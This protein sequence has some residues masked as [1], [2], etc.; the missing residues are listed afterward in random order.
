M[1]A[2]DAEVQKLRYDE[3]FYSTTTASNLES[4]RLIA[5]LL[6]SRLTIRSVVDFG[7]AE[8]GWLSVWLQLGVSEIQGLDGGAVNPE[9][10]LIPR[11]QFMAVD[12]SRPVDLERR[13]DLAMS[14]EVAE[15]LPEASAAILVASLTRH[16]DWVLFSASPPGQGGEYH[17]NEQPYEYWKELFENQ[18]YLMLDCVRPQI[19]HNRAVQSWYKYNTFLFVRKDRLYSMPSAWRATSLGAGE[20]VVDL[21]PWWY[22][23]RKMVVKML[24]PAMH[25]RTVRLIARYRALKYWKNQSGG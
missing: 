14:L 15:H 11:E 7:C 2:D 4:A 21:S 13:F 17:I 8:G 18:N 10:M 9:R 19:I 23:L 22:R 1:V 12:L 6:L 25:Q 24:S 3:L 5:S 20:S 16:A